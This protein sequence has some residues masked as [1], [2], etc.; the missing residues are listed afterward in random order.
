MTHE[1]D[2]NKCSMDGTHE[3][4]TMEMKSPLQEPAPHEGAP[5][6][7]LARE[8]TWDGTWEGATPFPAGLV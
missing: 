2:T 5:T 1:N 3:N 4:T 7:A 6:V 8:Q